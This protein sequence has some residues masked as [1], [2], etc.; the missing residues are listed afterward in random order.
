MFLTIFGELE[1]VLADLYPYRYL[2]TAVAALAVAGVAYL[3]MRRGFLRFVWNHR[4]ASAVV[5]IPILIL[6]V[7]LGTYLLSPL[8]ERSHLVE[9]SP[10]AMIT[11]A[12]AAMPSSPSSTSAA[13]S[14][15]AAS[16]SGFQPRATHGGM[17]K[18][19]DDF[20]FGRGDASLIAVAPGKTV[21]RFENFSVRNGPD[22]YV[23]LSTHEGA[24]R[25]D[26]ML[27]LGRLKATDGAFN[28]DI[29]AGVD[30]STIRSVIVW[31]K[32]FGVLFAEAPLL[33]AS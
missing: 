15:Q 16:L 6:G 19:A 18:G 27:N 28:Y 14:S 8:W 21:V 24:R 25:V 17:F 2:L 30:L 33:P 20:H 9:E 4:L 32:Q 26:Q 29:P 1:R 7:V 11:S 23:Y 13:P 10:L 31:C 22:L 12:D 5:G 3:L